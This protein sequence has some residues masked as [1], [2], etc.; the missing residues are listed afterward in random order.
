MKNYHILIMVYSVV[1]IASIVYFGFFQ[2]FGAR[3][4]NFCMGGR[5]NAISLIDLMIILAVAVSLSLLVISILAFKRT[6]DIK[7]L[8]LALAFFF[9]SVKE[10]LSA[11]EN[12]FP[13][14]FIYIDNMDKMLELLIFLSFIILLY[15]GYK[16]I[17]NKNRTRPDNNA[18]RKQKLS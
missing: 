7:M 18:R 14:E 3:N 12:F 4:L 13:G 17:M 8:I 10:F 2:H 1:I 9:F 5:D 11:F 6:N 16:N 15:A